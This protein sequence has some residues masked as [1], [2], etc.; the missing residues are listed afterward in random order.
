M[1]ILTDTSVWM[2][3]YTL[4]KDNRFDFRPHF[5]RFNIAV[6]GQIQ[7]ELAKSEYQEY[8]QKEQYELIEVSQKDIDEYLSH[9][10]GF[11]EL[12]PIDRTILIA[13]ERDHGLVLTDDSEIFLE[14]IS[15]KI[16]V[17]RFPHFCL[18]MALDGDIIWPE[19]SYLGLYWEQKKRYS[20]KELAEWQKVREKTQI[21]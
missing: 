5:R 13:A 11:E 12:D 2:H 14:C 4:I 7:E 21:K 10:N 1:L 8:W 16:L 6:T 3:V 9:Q 19:I 15:R 18:K 20:K 17:M